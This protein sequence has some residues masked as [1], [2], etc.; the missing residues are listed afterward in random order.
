M[1]QY[2][3]NHTNAFSINHRIGREKWIKS[4]DKHMQ[5]RFKNLLENLQ[6]KTILNSQANTEPANQTKYFEPVDEENS[7]VDMMA[8]CV[9]CPEYARALLELKIGSPCAHGNFNQTT[10]HTI[11]SHINEFDSGC[12]LAAV[13]FDP[14]TSQPIW[15]YIVL[16]PSIRVFHEICGGDTKKSNDYSMGYTIDMGNS[17]QKNSGIDVKFANTTQVL[18]KKVVDGQNAFV[19]CRSTSDGFGTDVGQNAMNTVLRKY[20]AKH[21][22]NSTLRIDRSIYTTSSIES[23]RGNLGEHI[24]NTLI[25]LHTTH[26]RVQSDLFAGS[27]EDTKLDN[28]KNIQM[29]TVKDCNGKSSQ[30]MFPIRHRNN[31]QQDVPYTFESCQDVICAVRHASDVHGN[32]SGFHDDWKA[33]EGTVS[34]VMVFT[35]DELVQLGKLG[36]LSMFCFRA[37][38]HLTNCVYIMNDGELFDD[39]NVN[40]QKFN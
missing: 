8:K 25:K 36:K 13:T 39:N 18:I 2:K 24:V 40:L 23:I 29:K 35:R 28:G 22:V 14:K 19:W 20:I 9:D 16:I 11:F 5:S 34:I 17:E 37:G 21:V 10:H 27:P 31:G 6:T 30:Q 33:P 32:H 38:H 26:T 12:C 15:L 3:K 1:K 4:F 7:H